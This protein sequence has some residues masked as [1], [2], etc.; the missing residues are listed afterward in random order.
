MALRFWRARAGIEHRIER[1]RRGGAQR[2]AGLPAVRRPRADGNDGA[3]R[4][5]DAVSAG[6]AAGLD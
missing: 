6:N 2:V 5:L 1:G 3:M 4:R